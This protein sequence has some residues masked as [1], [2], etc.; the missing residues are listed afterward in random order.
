[1]KKKKLS[2][3]HKKY[4][5]YG[6]LLIILSFMCTI[7]SVIIVAMNPRSKFAWV[8]GILLYGF[9]WILLLAGGFITGRSCFRL[10]RKKPMR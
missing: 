4:I 7:I 1:M 2:K 9:G 3:T 8:K 10:F 5:K 6:S